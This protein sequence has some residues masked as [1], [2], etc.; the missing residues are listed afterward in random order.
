MAL[1]RP[2]QG[3]IAMLFWASAN[4]C[5]RVRAICAYSVDAEDANR[6]LAR[7]GYTNSFRK[8]VLKARGID[9]NN[10]TM[11]GIPY[12]TGKTPIWDCLEQEVKHGR[13]A[14][15]DD[16]AQWLDDAKWIEWIED[17]AP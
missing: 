9:F 1:L 12:N 8:R 13:F 16:Q 5:N 11:N 3:E 14:V 17:P 10:P 15:W 6:N 7:Y 2:I 4:I